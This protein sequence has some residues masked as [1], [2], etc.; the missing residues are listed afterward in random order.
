MQRAKMCFIH[1]VADVWVVRR[2]ANL[3]QVNNHS[4]MNNAQVV[5]A[6]TVEVDSAAENNRELFTAASGNSAFGSAIRGP[7]ANPRIGLRSRPAKRFF[8]R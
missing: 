1:A 6:E 7:S 5:A 8:V 4:R 2:V 3:N